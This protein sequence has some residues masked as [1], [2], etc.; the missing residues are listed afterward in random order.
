LHWERSQ[1]AKSQSLA[2]D[3]ECRDALAL[4]TDHLLACA[5]SA[6][7][8]TEATRADLRLSGGPLIADSPGSSTFCSKGFTDSC[9]IPGGLAASI[10]PWCNSPALPFG[11]AA[12]PN[13]PCSC[14]Q[15]AIYSQ[16]APN[17]EHRRPQLR[18]SQLRD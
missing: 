1:P 2:P 8:Q 11:A 10:V 13:R 9:G 7:G 14:P 16:G 17:E 3:H 12:K 18:R 6:Q 5:K 15:S 4:S